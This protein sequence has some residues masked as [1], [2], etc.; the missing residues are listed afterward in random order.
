MFDNRHSA[1]ISLAEQLS[2]YKDAS[3]VIYALPRGGVAVAA[4]IAS[5]LKAPLDIILVRKIGLPGHEELAIGAI[6]N[7]KTP[8]TILRQ[9]VIR[10]FRIPEEKIEAS[11]KA[12]LQEIDHRRGL[13]RRVREPVSASGKTA[14]LVDDGLATGATME[15][16]VAAIRKQAPKEIIIAIP[17]A[18]RSTVERCEQL[19]D[20]VICLE[21]PKWF[22]AVGQRYKQFPQLTDEEVIT[23]LKSHKGN[24][25]GNSVHLHQQRHIQ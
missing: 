24:H 15:A 18:P 9:D 14:I 3:P 6:V 7:G 11:I 21:T 2:P 5:A 12:A 17:T 1:G 16:A 19:A 8:T 23:L 13:Y 10:E 22:V 4:P 20:A 25:T